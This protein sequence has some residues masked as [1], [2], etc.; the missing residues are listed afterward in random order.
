MDIKLF[1]DKIL[2]HADLECVKIIQAEQAEED[3]LIIRNSKIGSK[4]KVAV[5]SVIDNDWDAVEA[6]LT[7]KRV[8]RALKHMSRIVGYYSQIEN[9]NKSK[10]GELKDRQAGQYQVEKADKEK[11]HAPLNT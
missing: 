6:V 3:H 2:M 10:L 7:G 11:E 5:A 1:Y 9:W 4:Y 8:P